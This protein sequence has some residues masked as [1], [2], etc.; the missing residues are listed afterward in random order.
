[1]SLPKWWQDAIGYQ[2]YPRSFADANDDGIG[3][4]PGIIEK[5]DYIQ[6]L[7]VTLLW[8]SPFYPSPLFDMGYDVADYTAIASEYGTLAD[9]DRLIGEAH[10]RGIRIM[11]DV[12]LNH[13]STEHPWF[14]ASR[15]SKD[16]RYRD[17]YI[18]RPGKAE[19]EPPNDW[20]AGFGGSAWEYDAQ[21][22]EW[23]YHY[24]FKEQADLNWRNPAVVRALHESLRFW[25]ARGVAGFRLD[26]IEVIFEDEDLTP[27]DFPLSILQL[28]IDSWENNEANWNNSFDAKMRHQVNLPEVHDAI[29]DLRQLTDSYQQ[30]VLLGETWGTELYLNGQDGIHSAYFFDWTD[31]A[32]PNAPALRSA[33]K[34]RLPKVPRGA[35]DCVTV[36]NHDRPRLWGKVA[37][38]DALD[39]RRYELV[40]ATTMFLHGTP[41]FYNGEEI[42]MADVYLD[43]LS[44]FKDGIG[45]WAYHA[46]V[47]H[48]WSHEDAFTRTQQMI[49]R[50]K[51]RSPMQWANAPHAGFSSLTPWL[52]VHPNYA[53]GV[54]V[55]DQ[56]NDPESHL[57]RFRRLAR[58]RREYVA[59]RRGD[60]AVIAGTG[61]VFAAWRHTRQQSLLLA[62]NMSSEP[63]DAALGIQKARRAFSN[64]GTLIPASEIQRE[65]A[66][67]DLARLSLRPYEVFVGLVS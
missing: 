30:I 50:D 22:N 21:T 43:N 67:F 3:D 8:L 6:S 19:G 58:V 40:L 17:W 10:R 63:Q 53:E 18:W 31:I 64:Y 13:T 41:M 60:F 62:I 47:E 56:E 44:Q 4:L 25:L 14:K 48:G 12:V 7:G 55:A 24:F 39:D 27:A 46:L 23:Y 11:L 36:G 66:N 32:S 26:A 15:A 49:G 16:N 1:M 61:D 28:W 2:I 42:G 57:N 29:R 54:N 52:P 37:Q 20:E 38:A 65:N 51:N 59:L 34:K 9:F 45:L 35:W 5:L 33:L